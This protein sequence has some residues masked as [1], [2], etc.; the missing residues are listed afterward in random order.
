MAKLYG[1]RIDLSALRGQSTSN[2]LLPPN[3]SILPSAAHRH[4]GKKLDH[5]NRRFDILVQTIIE[6]SAIP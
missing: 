5:L 1:S 4:H 3:I 6:R 2:R